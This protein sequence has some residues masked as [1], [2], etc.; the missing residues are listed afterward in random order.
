MATKLIADYEHLQIYAFEQPYQILRSFG[1]Q[2]F[3]FNFGFKIKN[4]NTNAGT[5]VNTDIILNV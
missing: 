1:V 4:F 5:N 2:Q 3:V